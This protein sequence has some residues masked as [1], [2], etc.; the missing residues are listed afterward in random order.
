MATKLSVNVNKVAW[1]RNARPGDVPSVVEVSRA[2]LD[3]G[4]NES[5]A[6]KRRLEDMAAYLNLV[7]LYK[8]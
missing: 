2:A 5:P 1:L 7:V 6:V 8:Q 4:A 3:A